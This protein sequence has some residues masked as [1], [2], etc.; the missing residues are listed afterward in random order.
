[1]PNHI[2]PDT[3]ASSLGQSLVPFQRSTMI[4]TFN[5]LA[6]WLLG[7]PLGPH[8]KGP[9]SPVREHA[10]AESNIKLQSSPQPRRLILWTRVKAKRVNLGDLEFL[11]WAG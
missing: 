3:G 4:G 10:S 6:A 9:L 5:L 8:P 11:F 7:G 2:L 1:V